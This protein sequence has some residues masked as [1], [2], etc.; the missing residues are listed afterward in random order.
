M[1]SPPVFRRFGHRPAHDS[2]RSVVIRSEQGIRKPPC[3]SKGADIRLQTLISQIALPELAPCGF[4]GCRASQGRLPPPLLIRQSYSVVEQECNDLVAACQARLIDHRRSVQA[5]V[6]AGG[7][8]GKS[9]SLSRAALQHSSCWMSWY[10]SRNHLRRL[11]PQPVRSASECSPQR[12]NYLRMAPA[13]Q[14]APRTAG[15]GLST[16]HTPQRTR[17][18]LMIESLLAPLKGAAA[19]YSPG[20]IASA[21][22]ALSAIFSCSASCLPI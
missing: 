11:S 15:P 14:F 1:P 6:I 2:S 21:I 20:T 5:A 9:R 17:F 10:G 19:R 4:A 18:G 12:P 8:D 22:M 16:C 7:H 13:G 3:L